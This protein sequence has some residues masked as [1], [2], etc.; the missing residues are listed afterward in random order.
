MIEKFFS[1]SKKELDFLKTKNHLV[2]NRCPYQHQKTGQFFF[3]VKERQRSCKA[4]W[5]FGLIAKY[6]TG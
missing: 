1:A 3:D 6:P 2:E 4:L 5:V